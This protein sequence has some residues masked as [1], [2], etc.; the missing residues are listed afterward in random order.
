MLQKNYIVT[1]KLTTGEI[2]SSIT[3]L[4]LSHLHNSLAQEIKDVT[5][6]V[7]LVNDIYLFKHHIKSF[8]IEKK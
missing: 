3:A 8:N 2:K 1:F 4:S 6:P 7:F 5:T